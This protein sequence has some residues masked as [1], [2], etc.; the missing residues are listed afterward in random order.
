MSKAKIISICGICSAVA[1][2]CLWVSSLPFARWL[3][4][5]LAVVASLA[6]VVPLLA[7]GSRKYTLL[8]YIASSILGIFFSIQ[9]NLYMVV[10]IVAFCM[11]FAI[12]KMCAESVKVTTKFTPTIAEDPFGQGD[13]KTIVEVEVDSKKSMPSWLK[14]VLYYVLLEVGL[15]L[16]VLCL[17]LFVQFDDVW[18]MLTKNNLIWI[19]VG[20]LQLVVIPLDWLLRGCFIALAKI[21]RKSKLM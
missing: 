21:L 3:I 1:T 4:L 12:V 11:P 13:N 20:I 9:F 15:A 5:L 7:F 10:P 6:I 2:L 14:W 19:L 17:S 18:Q 8:C 16:T